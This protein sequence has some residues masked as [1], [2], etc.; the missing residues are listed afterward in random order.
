MT[1]HVIGGNTSSP[2]G[3]RGDGFVSTVIEL[4]LECNRG[5]AQ[6]LSK[7]ESEVFPFSFVAVANGARKTNSKHEAV[8][9]SRVMCKR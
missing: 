4:R 1:E 3:E 7:W 9:Q 8:N 2:Q 5:V 6:G